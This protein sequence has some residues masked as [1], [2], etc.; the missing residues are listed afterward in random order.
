[1]LV[2]QSFAVW[3]GGEVKHPQDP[4]LYNELSRIVTSQGTVIRSMRDGS[5]EVPSRHTMGLIH[6]ELFKTT[7][8]LNSCYIATQTLPYTLYTVGVVCRWLSQL[9]PGFWS[10]MG[11]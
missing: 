2:R 1:M 4:S 9:Q 10:S 11:A 8:D 5:T 6:T 7:D 3:G